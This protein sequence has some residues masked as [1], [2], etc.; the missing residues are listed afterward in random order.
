MYA[1]FAWVGISFAATCALI[2][3]LVM[4]HPAYDAAFF[5]KLGFT[6][7]IVYA[8]H[9]CSTEYSKERQLE[10]EYAFKG[11]IS[12]S[13]EPYRELVEKMVNKGN[14]S[15]S[16]KY[17]DFVLASIDRVFTPPVT[18]TNPTKQNADG[19]VQET[20]AASQALS[21]ILGSMTDFFQ[22]LAKLK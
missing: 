15:D 16:T 12:I 1:L 4:G 6:I 19:V 21:K 3:Y 17:L 9:F 5:L 18:S 10:E 7:P 11:N 8:I 13:L 20:G 22:S 2:V 14:E